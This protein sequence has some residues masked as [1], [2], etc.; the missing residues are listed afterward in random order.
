MSASEKMAAPGSSDTSTAVRAW[1]SFYRLQVVKGSKVLALQ[2]STE[3]RIPTRRP[4]PVDLTSDL[5]NFRH[6]VESF[7]G[8]RT[9]DNYKF[10]TAG[11]AL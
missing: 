5:S 6:H 3:E 7:C 8:L 9:D 2:K 10:N 11:F 4:I 1:I